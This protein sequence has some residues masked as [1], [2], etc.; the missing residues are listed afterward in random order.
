VKYAAIA[1]QAERKEYTVRFMC[2]QLGVST[3]GYYKWLGKPQSQHDLDDETLSMLIATVFA[4]CNRPGW[5]RVRAE[6]RVTGWH[7]GAVRVHRLMRQLGLSGRCPRA[8]KKTT[9]RGTKPVN[10]PDRIGRDAHATGPDQKWVGDITYIKTWKGWAYM[11][12]VIDLYSRK[13]VGWAIADHM[14]TSLVTAALD[15]AIANRHP[16]KGVIFHSDRG[17]QYTSREFARHCR[18][19]GVTRSLGHTG[20]CFDNSVS[21]S[22]N[23]TLKKELIHNRPWPDITYLRKA[24]FTWI[25]TQYNQ[26]RRHSYLNYLT[27]K[28]FELG[29]RSLDQ[30]THEQAT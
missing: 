6:L 19:H 8:W 26:R 12:T 25:E 14:E 24:V 29:Y 5:R 16:A 30:I 23:A 10:A 9:I 13:L 1:D 21:E 27:I 17:C 22:F 11:A 15:Q 4:K 18:D 7:V 20:N 3:S 28:E 2:K